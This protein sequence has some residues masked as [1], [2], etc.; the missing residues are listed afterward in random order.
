MAL[1]AYRMWPTWEGHTAQ[2][3]FARLVAT[4]SQYVTCLLHQF[5]H[6][7]QSEPARLR[8]LQA[9]ARRA[10]TDA[11]ASTARLA[12]E[13]PHPPLTP[14]VAHAFV[15]AVTRLAHA[16]L[17]LHAL[18]LQQAQSMAGKTDEPANKP[19]DSTH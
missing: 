18:L 7:D 1:I 12:N 10:R 8:N 17:A 11:E 5:A 2:Q 6:P 19:G 9:A 13:P 15:A 3:K 16:E 4:H 14:A